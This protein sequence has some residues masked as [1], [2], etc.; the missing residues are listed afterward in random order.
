LLLI[1]GCAA[2]SDRTF[3]QETGELSVVID[4]FHNDK[5][6][7]ILS[8]F[9]QKD[10][11]PKDMEK[12]WQTLQLNIESGRAHGIFTD[13]PYGEYALSILHDEDGDKQMQ[14]DWL[15]KPREGFGFSGQ[16]DYNFGPPGFSDA[17]FLLVSSSREV[18]IWIKYDTMRQKKQLERRTLQDGKS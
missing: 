1:S 11:F 7:A 12:A 13:V 2:K 3:A 18:V 14:K 6:E 9:A 5:G 8:L 10:G 17:A 15:G 4:G 16:P